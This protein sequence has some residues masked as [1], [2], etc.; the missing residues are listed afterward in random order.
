MN[1]LSGRLGRA[2][3]LR[4]GWWKAGV[5]PEPT[6]TPTTSLF[7]TAAGV[8]TDIS[9]YASNT[10][11]SLT[12]DT[13][14]LTGIT[15]A[16][17]SRIS[18]TTDAALTFDANHDPALDTALEQTTA[19]DFYPAGTAAGNPRYSGTLA[20]VNKR[21][22]DTDKSDANRQKVSLTGTITRTLTT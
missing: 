1:E 11:L 3:F 20:L 18:T 4:L 6:T 12:T 14:E 10:S 22:I 2:R 16:A 13:K 9:G 19:F 17:K 5:A 21:E 15:A 8:S 7:L